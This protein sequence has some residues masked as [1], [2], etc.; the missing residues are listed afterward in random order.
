[1]LN[2]ITIIGNLTRDPELTQ[3]PNGI[4]VCHF[5]VAVGRNYPDSNGEKQT[6][7][8]NCTAW[9]SQAET[10][11]KYCKKG[12]KVCV[13]GSMQ[14]RSYDKDGEKRIAWEI[15]VSETEFLTPKSSV[16]SEES[17]SRGNTQPPKKTANKPVLTAMEDDD[18]PF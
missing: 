6:D 3:T 15:Q 14:S 16:E 17:G 4:A 8:F 11:S 2:K 9:R 7:F 10:I 5:S 13:I 1:M 12:N 18:I